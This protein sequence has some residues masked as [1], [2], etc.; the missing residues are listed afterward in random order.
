MEIAKGTVVVV[1]GAS[2]GVGRATALAFA[3]RG[4]QVGLISRNLERMESLCQEIDAVGGSALAQVVDVSDHEELE[5]AANRVEALLGP[6]DVWVNNA[7]VSVFSPFKDM[8]N[9]EYRRVT[10]VTYLGTV[11]GTQ[12]ALK[13]MLPR[14]RGVVVQVGSALAD[15]SIPLQSAYC[16]AKHG[17]RGFTDSLR[18][19]LLHD[20]SGVHL[21][22][23]QLPA[24]NTPQFAWVKSRLPNKPQPVPPIFQP[25]VAAE[26]IVWAAQHRRRELYVGFPT[27]KAIWA[28]KF[29]PGLLDRYL[30]RFGYDSQQTDEPE[31]RNR[32]D[33][34]WHSVPGPFGAHGSFDRRASSCSGELWFSERKAVG[35]GLV[36]FGVT[37]LAGCLVRRRF[38]PLSALR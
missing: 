19:E 6:I 17:I 7:M 31:E 4:A 10:D 5:E 11:Y 22:M 30:A 1:T 13:R 14:N 18:C 28:N 32:P 36:A 24:L 29:F 38:P 12:V 15:R 8:T 37:L 33:N 21:T 23:V 25:E 34:L 35:L 3:R 16:G 9:E 20:R 27:V 26:A 2:A